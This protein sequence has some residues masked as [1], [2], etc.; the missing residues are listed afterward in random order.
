M[1]RFIRAAVASAAVAV[2]ALALG[3]PASATVTG[4]PAEVAPVVQA[5]RADWDPEAWLIEQWPS[6]PFGDRATFEITDLSAGHEL[7]NG[8]LQSLAGF[9]A[10][11]RPDIVLLD[12]EYVES[13]D[14][15]DRRHLL[16]VAVHE[17]SHSAV[18][19]D[20][21]V[22]PREVFEITEADRSWAGPLLDTGLTG[23]WAAL[24]AI[25]ACVEQSALPPGTSVYYLSGACPADYRDAAFDYLSEITGG[26]DWRP[27]EMKADRALTIHGAIGRL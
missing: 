8:S 16:A 26:T 21:G 20:G 9:V 6:L 24:E 1:R 5:A 14:Y 18:F 22:P 12:R 13:R 23:K 25:A 19:Q 2:L 17:L 3:A 7:P 11:D 10:A 4:E 27:Q 15:A